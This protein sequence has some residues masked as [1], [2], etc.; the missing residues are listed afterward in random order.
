MKGLFS[1]EGQQNQKKKTEMSLLKKVARQLNKK[2]RER[3][4]PSS[5]FGAT[6][7]QTWLIRGAQP[8]LHFVSAQKQMSAGEESDIIRQNQT[9]T[10]FFA[11]IVR[12]LPDTPPDKHRHRLTSD[13]HSPTVVRLF[14]TKSDKKSDAQQTLTDIFRHFSG[15]LRPSHIGSIKIQVVVYKG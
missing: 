8:L 13:R 1:R 3:N 14:R 7:R 15:Q 2:A 4:D 12:A 9:K 11:D 10:C 5:P 6:K